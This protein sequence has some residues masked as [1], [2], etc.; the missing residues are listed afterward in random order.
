LAIYPQTVALGKSVLVA[1][2]HVPLAAPG[3]TWRWPG[4]DG[5]G[6]LLY[7]ATG[8]PLSAANAAVT[9]GAGGRIATLVA[10]S[11]SSWGSSAACRRGLHVVDEEHSAPA[12]ASA[13]S[14]A[15]TIELAFDHFVATSVAVVAAELVRC[16]GPGA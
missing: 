2:P 7:T 3:A 14:K 4:R 16:G 8:V 5:F 15:E 6:T 1:G 10:R 12:A 13:E 11:S 9:T